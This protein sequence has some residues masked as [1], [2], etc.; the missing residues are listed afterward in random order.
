MKLSYEEMQKESIARIPIYTDEWTSTAPSDPGITILEIVTAYSARLAEALEDVT[1]EEEEAL[2]CLA[3]FAARKGSPARALVGIEK[4]E[5][6]EGCAGSYP[7]RQKFC[8]GDICFELPRGT[9]SFRGYIKAVYTE[10]DGKLAKMQEAWIFGERPKKGGS[11][12]LLIKMEEGRP[13]PKRFSLFAEVEEDERRNPF[14]EDGRLKF[15]Q[16]SWSCL[17]EQG[18]EEIRCEDQTGPFLVSGELQ[19][20]LEGAKASP[21]IL[22][23]EEG[24][25]LRGRL[26]S[27]HYDI[28]PRLRHIWGPLLPVYEMDTKIFSYVLKD[29]EDRETIP[30]IFGEEMYCLYCKREGEEA[31]AVCCAKSMMPHRELGLVEGY[32]GQEIDLSILPTL[33][34]ESIELMLELERAGKKEHYFFRQEDAAFPFIYEEQRRRIVILDPGGFTGASMSLSGASS[35]HGERGNIRAGSRLAVM[36]GA[37]YEEG[38]IFFTPSG[39]SGGCFPE[40]M[41]ELKRR[42]RREIKDRENAVT[43]EDYERFLREMPGFIIEKVKAEISQEE[44]EVEIRILTEGEENRMDISP[45][46]KQKILDYLEPVRMLGMQIRIQ[47][48]EER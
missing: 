22:G 31:R 2:L 20:D 21:G 34:A 47:K 11:V 1:E 42:F 17:T 3:G 33:L 28:A 45:W 14:L 19:L 8:V 39:G 27:H 36:G 30:N 32:A 46:T 15:A 40:N 4:G 38:D 44:R 37:A 7:A 23:G 10:Q 41:E 26:E 48:M 35:Y 43:A 24:Y 16:V 9:Q 12:Y 29:G 18:Y 25:I 6:K 13:L 5:I